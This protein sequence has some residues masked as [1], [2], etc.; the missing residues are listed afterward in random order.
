MNL[1]LPWIVSAY[2]PVLNLYPRRFKDEFAVEIHTVFRD[3]V[4]DAAEEGTLSLLLVCAREFIG[5]PLN[6]LKEFWHEIQ[7]KKPNMQSTQFSSWQP[8]SWADSVL[9]GI[10]STAVSRLRTT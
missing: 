2:A 8:R 7:G 9:A 10:A 3:S 1:F 6:I 4:I 5:L